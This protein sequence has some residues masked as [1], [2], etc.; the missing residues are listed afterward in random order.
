MIEAPPGAGF[1]A[2][3]TVA[4][5]AAD[6]RTG[7][8]SAADLV[9]H[10][11][12]EAARS[13]LNAFVTVDEPG[14]RAAAHRAADELAAGVDRGPLHGIPVAV[15]D[16][17]DTAGLRTTMG[18]RHFADRVP[19]RDAEC[20]RRLRE[21]GAVVVGKTVTHEFAYGPTGDK[22]AHGP[23]HNPYRP[24]AM[25]GGSSAGSAVAVAAGIVP[26]AVG[27]D[28]G[29][30]VRIPAA[31]CGV[32]GLRPTYGAVPVDGV[33]P[34]SPTLDS[35]GPLARTIDDCRLMWRVLAG[36]EAPEASTR[37]VRIGW[38]EPEA[39]HP[40]D[41]AVTAAARKLVPDAETVEVPDARVLLA[42]YR[43]IQSAEAYEIHAERV[44]R[45]PE[46]FGDELVARLRV[47]E[48]V[49]GWEY[50]RAL[51]HRRRAVATVETLFDG[52]DVL[53]LP[54]L[55]ITAPPIGARRTS[56]GG[57]EVDVRAALLSQ[58]SPWSV[59]GL[60]ALSVPAGLVDGMPAGLQLVANPGG[61]EL[62]FVVAERLVQPPR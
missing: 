26:L 30:S 21:A 58:T 62:L 38:V 32:T 42:D 36:R 47:A 40:A 22:S 25:S 8:R 43:L 3:H 54:T 13:T 4:G 51:E 50:V 9:E 12:A 61:E 60:P 24:D 41:E 55:P 34:L 10:A 39:F 59:L 27:T 35:V 53:A 48:Q 19:D 17:V 52:Q 1:F 15:K 46:L 23:A 14:A 20:V 37:P 57:R 18:S 11:L 33:F 49:R 29:G 6:L 56:A 28:T 45:A 2:T 16:L 5:L 7:R 44:A 31:A